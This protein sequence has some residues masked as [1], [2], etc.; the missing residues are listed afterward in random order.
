MYHL[1]PLRVDIKGRYTDSNRVNINKIKRNYKEYMN[2]VKQTR[3]K[4]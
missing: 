3:P 4:C 2:S 1:A